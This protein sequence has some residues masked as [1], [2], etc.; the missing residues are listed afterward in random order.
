MSMKL[1]F[2]FIFI[3]L[4]SVF[5][6]SGLKKNNDKNIQLNINS[7]Q[8]DSSD[9][10]KLEENEYKP[11]RIKSIYMSQIEF[12]SGRPT[13]S[14][15]IELFKAAFEK[16]VNIIQKL[17]DVYR[18]TEK[19]TITEQDYTDYLL[20]DYKNSDYEADLVIFVDGSKDLSDKDFAKLQIIKK[21][22]VEGSV[23]K[24]RPI[25]G[26]LN[27]NLRHR[28]FYLPQSDDYIDKIYLYE[29]FH[30][31][32]H[33]LGFEKSILRSKSKLSTTFSKRVNGRNRQRLIAIGGKMLQTAK[34]YFGYQD[35]VGIEFDTDD[36]NLEGEE[37][38]HWDKRLMLGDYMTSDMY[39]PDQVISEITLALLEDLGWYQIKY[40]TGGLMRFGKNKG[41]E[42]IENDCVKQKD[43]K[44][45]SPS[46]LNEFCFQEGTDVYGTCSPGRQSRGYCLQKTIYNDVP[47]F[48]RRTFTSIGWTSNYGS[49]NIEYCPVTSETILEETYKYYIGNCNIGNSNYGDEIEPTKLA[50]S[51]MSADFGE[52]LGENSLCALSSIYDKNKAYNGALRP[53]CYIMHCESNYLI[54]LSI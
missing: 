29:I 52:Q 38:L 40:Y 22:N 33:F 23:N 34:N 12:F 36:T 13:E 3:T 31:F 18:L 8:N 32:T 49:K 54:I 51:T 15:N 11:I 7:N 47:E 5:T 4:I 20:D 48:F 28:T 24:G 35:L 25:V 14:K 16:V 9:K 39:Y 19:I 53:T 2:Y 30:E 10:R 27:F 26:Y 37:F 43:E 42:F 45:I 1:I 17:V 21:Y 41:K 50:Y 6:S 46:F 44:T